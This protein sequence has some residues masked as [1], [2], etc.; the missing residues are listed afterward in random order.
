MLALWCRHETM[1]GSPSFALRV[2]GR[3]MPGVAWDLLP[4]SKYRAHNWHCLGHLQREP[5]AAI[6]GSWGC[7]PSPAFRYLSGQPATPGSAL[8]DQYKPIDSKV[9]T[10][11][12]A[13][14][15]TADAS[16]NATGIKLLMFIL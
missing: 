16:M 2:L 10:A 9:A 7:G 11:L 6:S 8:G 4:M 3:E 13:A 14:P 12:G 1:D 15:A 5:Y